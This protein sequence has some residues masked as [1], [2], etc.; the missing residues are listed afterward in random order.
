MAP[1]DYTP[2]APKPYDFVSIE[3]LREGDRQRPKGHERY[4]PDTVSGLLEAAL[5][6]ATPLHVASGDIH[7]R[8]DNRTP[9]VRALARVN[10]VPC[11]PASTVKGLVRSVVE[12][13]THSCVRI[14][15][16]RNEQLPPGA[17]GCK[18]KENLCLACRMFGSLGFE[19]HVRFD[20]AL[21]TE[22]KPAIARMPALYAP[23]SRTGAYFSG[24]DVKGRK[25]YKH[26]RTVVDSQT[27]VEIIRPESRLSLTLRFDNLSVGELGVLLT[28]LGVGEPPLML[29]LGGG[30]PACYGSFL[31]QAQALRV[32]ENPQQ[33]Y[34]AYDDAEHSAL[35]AQTCFE[36]ARE[37]IVK[38]NLEKLAQI[39][40]YDMGRTCPEGNY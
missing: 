4:H 8:P 5:I 14:T 22:G 13:I 29:K 40:E 26:G 17:A 7:L 23:R 25:F 15:R 9:L 10:D 12:S 27:P 18:R 32:W 37:L 16:A 35:E 36:A 6:V 33:L 30:K 19:G 21:L 24:R 1:R 2:T 39:W 20:D 31:V 34:G 3:P 38:R 11:I 28:A